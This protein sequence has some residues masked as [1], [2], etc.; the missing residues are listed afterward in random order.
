MIILCLQN[1]KSMMGDHA[2]YILLSTN[3]VKTILEL[4]INEKI[5]SVPFF[6]PDQETN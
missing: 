6:K 1:V 5:N 2:I 3:Y 4:L